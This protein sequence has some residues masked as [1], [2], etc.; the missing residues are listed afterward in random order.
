MA[1]PHALEVPTL[2]T[3]SPAR[4]YQRARAPRSCRSTDRR[5][6]GCGSTAS[7]HRPQCRRRAAPTKE[8]DAKATGA[9]STPDAKNDEKSDDDKAEPPPPEINDNNFDGMMG[10]GR[11]GLEKKFRIGLRQGENEIV[12]KVVFGGGASR[13]GRPAAA[14][15]GQGDMGAGPRGNGSFTFQIT[16]EGDDVLTHEVATAV[17]L[18]ARSPAAATSSGSVASASASKSPSSA[19][20]NPVAGKRRTLGDTSRKG[21]GAV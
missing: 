3:T 9:A 12:V 15:T 2:L 8:S 10:R 5:V 17:R 13:S 20:S 21:V 14:A 19:A 1:L 18:E 16:P 4:S 11:D 7:W 6:S